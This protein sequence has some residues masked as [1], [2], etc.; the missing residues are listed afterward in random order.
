MIILKTSQ[1][2]NKKN[3]K[4]DEY[5]KFDLGSSVSTTECTGLMQNIPMDEYELESYYDVY[6]FAPPIE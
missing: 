6:D 4:Q 3:L 1:N 5:D 2:K